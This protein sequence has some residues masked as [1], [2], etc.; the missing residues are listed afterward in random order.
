MK[1]NDEGGY[2]WSDPDTSKAAAQSFSATHLEAIVAGE[3]A[4]CGNDGATWWELHV[5]SGIPLASISPRFKPLRGKG[6]IK[7]K[8]TIDGIVVK[9][10]G[11]SKRNQ[12]VWVKVA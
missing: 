6:I 8:T 12:I 2:R 11:N 1:D 10:P 9:R 3:I 5:R 4:M 7:A